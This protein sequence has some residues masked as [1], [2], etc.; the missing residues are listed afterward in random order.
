ML[1][2][3]FFDLDDTL[4]DYTRAE[5]IA[6]R[7]VM[8]ELGIPADGTVEQKFR[9][10]NLCQLARLEEGA[11]TWGQIWT[12]CFAELFA[13]LGIGTP[14]E[15]ASCRYKHYLAQGHDL[16]PGAADLLRELAP[17][18]DLYITSNGVA[19]VQ[20]SR[21][22]GA[23]ILPYFKGVFISEE[24]G[25]DKPHRAFYDA[26]FSAIPTLSRERTLV[27]GDRLTSDIRGGRNAGL[28]TCWFNPR[29]ESRRSDLVPDWEIAAL[30][31]L[32]A[33]L[34]RM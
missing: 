22:E 10:I 16:I 11:C 8:A 14:A 12:V 31:E 20:R 19:A 1:E 18:Y 28:R 4:L 24:V 33:L 32:P 17:R 5:S 21:L 25:A 13:G 23:G 6:L 15:E 30:S 2:T 3:I 26:C 7:K 29:K 27:V 9:Q 34:E